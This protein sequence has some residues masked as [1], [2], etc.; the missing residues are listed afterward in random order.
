M[1]SGWLASGSEAA[2][3]A[4]VALGA[5]RAGR[6]AVSLLLPTAAAAAA[7]PLAPRCRF[8]LPADSWPSAS[9]DRL[10]PPPA[11]AALL[12]PPAPAPAGCL[13]LPPLALAVVPRPSGTAPA[14]AASLSWLRVVVRRTLAPDRPSRPGAG[15]KSGRERRGSRE[16]LIG[17]GDRE[18]AGMAGPRLLPCD[19]DAPAREHSQPRDS[20][21]VHNTPAAMNTQNWAPGFPA[22]NWRAKQQQRADSRTVPPAAA[23]AFSSA[24]ERLPAEP[25]AAPAAACSLTAVNLKCLV[26]PASLHRKAQGRQAAWRHL[27]GGASS[28]RQV[29]ACPGG[30]RNASRPHHASGQGAGCEFSAQLS[31][32]WAAPNP[33][34]SSAT[35]MSGTSASAARKWVQPDGRRVPSER[36]PPGG[37]GVGWGWEAGRGQ[38]ELMR[39]AGRGCGHSQ[40]HRAD[41]CCGRAAEPTWVIARLA[42]QASRGQQ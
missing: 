15:P 1:L 16:G 14:G 30:L 35:S 6:P 24:L 31:V 32:L 4:A 25:S 19:S 34:S 18:D 8:C 17:A 29:G 2:A 40:A 13:P 10:M 22:A 23:A 26:M 9:A 38:G 42:G 20:C 11:L 27:K 5:L 3:A 21:L 36:Y 41:T 12:P 39:E 37:R 7:S 28:R 33:H